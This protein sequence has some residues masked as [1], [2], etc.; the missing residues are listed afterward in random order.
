MR[1]YETVADILRVDE[2][3]IIEQYDIK[4]KK[5]RP[6]D[7]GMSGIYSGDI[8]CTEISEAKADEIIKRWAENAD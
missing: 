2:N 6:A 1:Y 8:E 7:R 5:W 4:L 3:G